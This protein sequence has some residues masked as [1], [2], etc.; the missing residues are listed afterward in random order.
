MTD[1]DPLLTPKEVADELRIDKR[2]VLK[3]LGDGTDGTIPHVDLG[4]RTK[5]VRRSALDTFLT[6]QGDVSTCS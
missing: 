2:K 6:Q 4:Y 3:M 1:T 5:R